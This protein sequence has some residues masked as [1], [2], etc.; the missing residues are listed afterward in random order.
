M[1]TFVSVLSFA[2]GLVLRPFAI[3]TLVSASEK[4]PAAPA[5]LITKKGLPKE[6]AKDFIMRPNEIPPVV[7]ARIWTVKGLELLQSRILKCQA[8]ELDGK[9]L[10]YR[11]AFVS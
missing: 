10:Y 1:H 8:R 5:M 6:P 3:E 11:I 2:S 7:V 4:S 9:S